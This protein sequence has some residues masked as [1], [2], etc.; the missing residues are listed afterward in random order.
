MEINYD[1]LKKF[2]FNANAKGYA[3]G[4]KEVL[5]QRPGFSELE[6]VEG[7]YL[8]HDSYCGHYFAPGQEIVYYKNKPIWAMAYAGGMKF[9]FHD[10]EN[11]THESFLFLKKALLAMD[12]EKPYRGP[13]QYIDGEFKYIS[14]LDGDIKDFV[15]NEKIYKGDE[16]IFEQNFIGGII[17]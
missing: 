13:A 17:V 7:D 2:L 1:E 9:K 6:Y 14:V 10:D 16:L 4:G 5:P 15:G 8:Y 11:T 12:P 3:G